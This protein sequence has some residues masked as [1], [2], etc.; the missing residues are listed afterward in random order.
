MMLSK[1]SYMIGLQ[2]PLYLWAKFN[3]PSLIPEVKAGVR[4][5][6]DEGYLVGA[7]AKQYFGE[8]IDI[9]LDFNVNLEKTK[10]SIDK[11]Q[12]LFEP[13]FL[14]DNLFSRIDI[15]KPVKDG[16]DLIEVKSSTKVK[17]EHYH[18]VSF[19]RFVC[20]KAGLKIKKCYLMYI[21]K[22]FIKDGEIDLKKY[23]VLCDI[24]EQVD[25]ISK[26]IDDRISAM[27][28]IIKGKKPS[29]CIGGH[30]TMPY[31]CPITDCWKGLSSE[32]VFEL[33]RGGRKCEK[34]F[35]SGITKIKDIPDE[36][37][38]T[39]K[40]EIQRDCAKTGKPHIHK[41]KLKHF[42]KIIFEPVS[43]LDFETFQMAVPIYDGTKPYQ[44]IPFQFSL[45]VDDG[46][47]VK[48][49]SFLASGAIDP[50]LRFMEEL[51]KAL[52]STGS[53]IVYSK[54]FEESRLNE[55]ASMLPQYKKWVSNV[56]SR[57]V[58]LLDVFRGFIYYHPLQHGSASI[59]FV[60]PALLGRDDYKQL[61]ITNG[62]DATLAYLDMYHSKGMSEHD[63]NK[64]RLALEKYCE[65]D[66]QAMVLVLKELNKINE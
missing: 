52:P 22:N 47:S 60:L 34:L 61:D 65:L 8:G 10:Q 33:Y 13:G 11:G 37:K 36:F 30:C 16:W 28:T 12:I 4:H 56:S 31:E 55:C 2:C 45:H 39:D 50:R 24:T 23:F 5:R 7:L 42:L 21:N 19:Q 27:F 46:K 32:N 35:S 9:P 54:S 63:I 38:L 64:T 62:G 29:I 53:I 44:Q 58:D 26:G 57:I 59:K 3:E 14:V 15:L 1:S 40:Q 49:Y 48:H 18:D 20:N 43:Y 66:T 17:D 6:F 25:E 51:E 41:E